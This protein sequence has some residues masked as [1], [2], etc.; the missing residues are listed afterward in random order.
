MLNVA[1]LREDFPVLKNNPD[2]AYL[3]NAASTLKPTCVINEVDDYYNK[4]G[5]NVHRGVYQLSYLAT[6]AYEE[7]R[8]KVANFLSLQS[9]RN[10][11]PELGLEPR[12]YEFSVH[13]CNQLNYSGKKEGLL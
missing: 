12:N 1:K 2:L 10:S 13:C 7:A 11:K 3:D 6:D 9:R 5:V 8:N 4:L